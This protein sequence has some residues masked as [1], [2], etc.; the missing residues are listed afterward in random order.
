MEAS[1]TSAPH[2][3][4]RWQLS[5]TDYELQQAGTLLSGTRFSSWTPLN[6][7]RINLQV[8]NTTWALVNPLQ[9]NFVN[10]ISNNMS[11]K[12]E[13]HLHFRTVQGFMKATEFLILKLHTNRLWCGSN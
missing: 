3:V 7:K 13:L 1:L 6:N 10:S 4:K 8:R 11:L 5:G 12:P 2:S 9:I